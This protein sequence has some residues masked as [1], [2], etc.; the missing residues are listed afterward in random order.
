MTL[1]TAEDRQT[2]E[3]T[4]EFLIC[5]GR[6]ITIQIEGQ[7][8]SYTSTVLKANYGGVQSRYGSGPHL[9]IGRLTPEDG[10][11]SIKPGS[12]LVVKFLHTT[13]FCRFKTQ[14]LG[15]RSDGSDSE[16]IVSFPESIELPERRTRRRSNDEIP[17]FIS[18]V[19]TSKKGSKKDKNYELAVVDYSTN[20]VGILVSEK[21]SELVELVQEGDRLQ[22]IT[23]FASHTMV[24][25][26]GT[27][28]HKS[29]QQG[30]QGKD[31][32]VLGIEFDETLMD[33]G[34][35]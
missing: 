5:H 9:V 28:R 35:L 6:Q 20:G 32:Y 24:K 29:K 7:G 19:L 15:P 16:L 3:E 22:D 14:Y 17:E 1:Y 26:D 2:I 31:S 18:V 30:E 34:A 25:V 33:F 10:N 13:T 21:D 8:T 4:I 11:T 12:H 23:L 27:V